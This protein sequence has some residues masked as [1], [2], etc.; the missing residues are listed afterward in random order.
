M[1]PKTR[2]SFLILI[3][4]FVFTSS[5]Y[6][7]TFA[8]ENISY[9]YNPY[10]AAHLSSVVEKEGESLKVHFLLN[11]TWNTKL[12]NAF[13]L[14]YSLGKY[15]SYS[16]LIPNIQIPIEKGNYDQENGVYHFEV[17]LPFS[18]RKKVMLLYLTTLDDRDSYLFDINLRDYISEDKTLASGFNV[19]KY[20]KA[21]DIKHKNQFVIKKLDLE[22]K[23]LKRAY[24]REKRSKLLEE[25]T[26]YFDLTK[27]PIAEKLNSGLYYAFQNTGENPKGN[28]IKIVDDKYPAYDEL[29]PLVECLQY[30]TKD[31]EYQE[32]IQAKDKKQAFD[33]FWLNHSRSEIKAR[34]AIKLF[35][36]QIK[37][38]NNFFTTH[39]DGWKTDRGM[40]FVMFG[41]PNEVFKNKRKE[42]WIY[43][44]EKDKSKIK[45]TFVKKNSF[46]GRP[47]Y[48][49]KRKRRY[50][51]NWSRSQDIWKI[52]I[53][54]I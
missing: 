33:L 36:S 23:K 6:A 19:E 12:E 18:E 10:A 24:K 20:V 37:W 49:L 7:Q 13:S 41:R 2:L 42:H 28:F 51:K 39:E 52:G 4:C 44:N 22:N 53:K 50:K 3:A 25:K 47:E 46:T 5:S 32:I 17:L 21:S 30:I 34:Q 35:Y 8:Y 27:N 54:A 45:F 1:N 48:R 15:H 31:E 43:Y 11:S 40:V 38:A 16:G 9:H 26:Y 29:E 14:S